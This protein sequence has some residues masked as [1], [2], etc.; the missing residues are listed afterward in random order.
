M[1]LII[2]K[3]WPPQ[4]PKTQGSQFFLLEIYSQPRTPKNHVNNLFK[5]ILNSK[6]AKNRSQ[7]Q[8]QPKNQFLLYL[9]SNF[10]RHFKSKKHS[11]Q[12]FI[13]ICNH[14][15][16]NSNILVVGIKEMT[17]FSFQ[18]TPPLSILSPISIQIWKTLTAQGPWAWCGC[19]TNSAW[20]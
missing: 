19:Q 1:S 11:S 10:F 5:P 14:L 3:F 16:Q 17:F 8:N 2:P 15:K 18:T 9:R 13:V 4:L 20:A 12:T 6:S 7:T